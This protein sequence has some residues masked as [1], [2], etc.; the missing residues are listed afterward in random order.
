M[1]ASTDTLH[2]SADDVLVSD[3]ESYDDEC[4]HD[5]RAQHFDDDEYEH[6]DDDSEH[7]QSSVRPQSCG[8]HEA[9][10][11]DMYY[12]PVDPDN[13]PIPFD[14]Q[15][16]NVCDGCIHDDKRKFCRSCGS[17]DLHQFGLCCDCVDLADISEQCML[18]TNLRLGHDDDRS[19]AHALLGHADSAAPS[20]GYSL[21]C[22]SCLCGRCRMDPSYDS[23]IHICPRCTGTSGLCKGCMPLLHGDNGA[24]TPNQCCE[25]TP[26]T[27][28]PPPPSTPCCLIQVNMGSSLCNGCQVG[29]LTQYDLCW[30][31]GQEPPVFGGLRF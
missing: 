1:C 3:E 4:E 25:G 26:H 8:D 10:H 28:H 27:M 23:H 12:D 16:N 13:I 21:M 31:C 24:M 11:D 15:H 30:A 29:A 19:D 7:D 14:L 5:C 20:A 6:D 22:W 2:A 17:P 9:D 18:C